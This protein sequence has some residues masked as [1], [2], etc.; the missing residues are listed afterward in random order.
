MTEA[1]AAPGSHV[2]EPERCAA[3]SVKVAR[4]I[5]AQAGTQ[6]PT[7]AALPHSPYMACGE[8][9]AELPEIARCFA[10]ETRHPHCTTSATADAANTCFEREGEHP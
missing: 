9:L 3:R 4:I 5:A 6:R 2:R 10:N 7:R 8:K 1:L